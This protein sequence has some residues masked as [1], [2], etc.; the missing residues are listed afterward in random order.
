M[1]EN[2]L[3]TLAGAYLLDESQV[4]ERLL[5]A[6]PP[7]NHQIQ[8]L[9]AEL[10]TAVRSQKNKQSFFSA[11]VQ[12]YSINNREGLA[13]MSLAE[14][15]LRIPDSA[16]IR[17]LIADK[18]GQGNFAEH[19]GKSS[20]WLVNLNTIAL[21]LLKHSLWLPGLSY[22]MKAI[23][24]KLGG[25]FVFG[26]TI[27]QALNNANTKDWRYS[28][29]MLGEAALT[30]HDAER[31]F[32]SYQHA[33]QIIGRSKKQD[34]SVSIKLSALHPRY[35]YLQ[36]ERVLKELVPT[37]LALVKQAS[38]LDVAVTIDAEE[39]S[40]LEVSLLVFE[41]VFE[42]L[43]NF[44]Q[45]GLVVQAYQKRVLPAIDWLQTL[46][47]KH[48]KRI[49]VRLVKGAYWDTEIKKAQQLGLEDYPVYSF[50]AATD[51]SY[52]VA[53]RKLM[54]YSDDLTPQFAT[55]NA[56]TIASVLTYA[57]EYSLTRFEFQRLHGMGEETYQALKQIADIPCRVYAPVG[58]HPDLLPYLIRRLLENGANSSFVYHIGNQNIPITRLVQDPVIESKKM[59][60]PPPK[61]YGDRKNSMG[62]E[63]QSTQHYEL[64]KRG[65]AP[66]LEKY[67][68]LEKINFSDIK[69]VE[70][71]LS[72][73]HE[74]W[75]NWDKTP[76][77]QRANCLI[78]M[79][80]LLEVHRF[81]L[82]ALCIKEGGKT[83]QDAID[84]IR[85]AV[86]F[87]RYYAKL[88]SKNFATPTELPGPTGES[89]QLVLQGRGVF[90]CI[91]PWN[92]P[93]AIFIGQIAAALVVGNAVIAKPAEQTPR[94]AQL[95]TK[96]FHQAGIPQAVFQCLPGE[97]HVVGKALVADI[98]VAG[99]AFTGSTDTAWTIN[100][101]LAQKKG[102][103]VPFIAETGGQNAM[104]V[105]SSALPEQVVQDVIASAFRSAGQRCS[106]LRVLFLQNDIADRVLESLKGAMAE[107]TIGD[108]TDFSTDIGPVIDQEAQQKLL[109]YL[110][111]KNFYY[112]VTL[113]NGLNGYFVPPVIIEIN[114][115]NEIPGEIFGPVLHVIR[116]DSAELEKL[117]ETI[118][119]T[120]FGLTFGIHSRIES[121]IR[122][123][124]NNIRAG[125]VYVNRNMIGAVVG[126]QPFGGQGLSGTGPKAGG[127]HYLYCF[128]TEKTITV[129]TAAI[130]GNV[131]LLSPKKG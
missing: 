5:V 71:A 51:L 19:L 21:V 83:I 107:L 65:I 26:E 94:I 31:F 3:R 49:P 117:V 68:T 67:Q 63:M 127:P 88:A 30:K 103:I 122:L 6:A 46:A 105:D 57:K 52:L 130:G 69:E 2:P 76:V 79:A 126:V 131:G 129:N 34:I 124:Q 109:D 8:K 101:S 22:P 17:C 61:L 42:A 7:P 29:D 98:R 27:E 40:R 81:E 87:C 54:S 93:L 78:K 118:N 66:F 116:Y 90:I 60:V 56:H 113:P 33:I 1:S 91:S 104:I 128:A 43:P 62:F 120:G 37:L 125:N 9:A 15:L 32:K 96:L 86:D 85:E 82:V 18:I 41:K 70:R 111:N 95:A 58:R 115:I 25:H 80:D 89:N 64:F 36:K 97:G 75:K 50:K 48:H 13:L 35:E 72:M 39:A 59:I 10:I 73:A 108:P 99:V 74:A 14:C 92:F 12:E 4:I 77:I 38:E 16:T 44:E 106:A 102:P 123:L 121:T 45:F 11:F 100:Q 20:S 119:A 114:N 84:E 53:A 28:F 55:H 47:R 112:Q 110:K 23:M 24:Q